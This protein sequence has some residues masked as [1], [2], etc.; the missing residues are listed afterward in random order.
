MPLDEKHPH[1][2]M[3]PP[4][5]LSVGMVLCFLKAVPFF[6]QALVAVFL[7]NSSIFISSDQIT[8]SQNCIPFFS[9]V[10]TNFNWSLTCL[11][12][13][14]GTFLGDLEWKP[15]WYRALLMVS[16]LTLIPEWVMKGFICIFLLIHLEVCSFIFLG[17]PFLGR[18]AVLSPY[19]FYFLMI[20]LIVL[21]ARLISLLIFW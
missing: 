19:F 7:P 20:F 17:F 2:I 8:F 4:P 10:S 14:K 18:F 3:E 12:F 1:I 6:R 16:L 9:Y 15:V 11:V 13:S 5:N 21:S